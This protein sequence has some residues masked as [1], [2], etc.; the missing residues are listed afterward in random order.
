MIIGTNATINKIGGVKLT[1]DDVEL[2]QVTKYKYLGIMLDNK[3]SFT[4]H[5]AYIGSKGCQG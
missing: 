5:V 3:L 2:Q 1:I 4:K